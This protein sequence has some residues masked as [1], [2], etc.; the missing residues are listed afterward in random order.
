MPA[1]PHAATVTKLQRNMFMVAMIPAMAV[2]ME[3]RRPNTPVVDQM[4]AAI[5]LFVFGF[6]ALSLI[7]TL[8]DAGE[9][10]F[11]GLLQPETWDGWIKATTDLAKL[12]LTAATASVGLGTS[13]ARLRGLGLRPLAVGL[14]ADAL[15]GAMSFALVSLIG[16]YA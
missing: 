13:F 4:K 6:V 2:A 5:P 12:L 15:A 3:K 7:R 14:A 1:G 11:W 9:A 10:P 8:G 16:P